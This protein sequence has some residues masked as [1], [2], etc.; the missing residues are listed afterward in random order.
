VFPSLKSLELLEMATLEEVWTTTDGFEIQEEKLGAQ[1]C[2][3]V[4]SNLSILDCPQL[5]TVKP[6]LPPSL[7]KL[8]LRKTKLQLSP[9]SWSRRMHSEVLHLRELQLEGMTGSS[10]G[11]EYLRYHTNLK[12]LWIKYCNDRWGILSPSGDPSKKKKYC[13][14]LTQVPGSIR[15]LTSLQRLEITDCPTLGAL[16]EW[17]GELCSLRDLKVS[18]TPM[19]ASLPQSIGHLASLTRLEIG[20]WGNLKLLPDAI[21]HLTSLEHLELE[22]CR[23]LAELPEGIGQL[24]T[25][26]RLYIR[27]C[28]ALRSL[29]QSIQR[30]NALQSLYIIFC[31]ALAMRYK[32]GVGP[33]CHL[34]SHIPDL[35]IYP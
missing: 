33:D 7:E 23:A 20:G 9:A 19:I 22:H 32:Q 13:N 3:P 25:L 2:F 15:S 26:Q 34:V 16:P 28:S 24:S 18:K 29:P 31:P 5:S 12:T 17:L 4:L 10:S 21:Q 6:Y 11:W 8:R 14:D 1:Y 35:M 27:G 30:L